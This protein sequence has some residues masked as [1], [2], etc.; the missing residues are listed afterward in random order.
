MFCGLNEKIK[1]KNHCLKSKIQNFGAKIRSVKFSFLFSIYLQKVSKQLILRS[2]RR[3][4][5][6]ETVFA[7]VHCTSPL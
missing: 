3:L 4:A 7:F 2:P 6:A 5:C 1:K